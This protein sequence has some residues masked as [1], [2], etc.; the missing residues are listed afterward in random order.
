MSTNMNAPIKVICRYPI[1]SADMYYAE[2]GQRE[3]FASDDPHKGFRIWGELSGGGEVSAIPLCEVFLEYAMLC[4]AWGNDEDAYRQMENFGK[5]LGE[6]A[7][8]YIQEYVLPE[9]L[10]NP[11][12][13]AL[14]CLL[15]SMNAN[16]A[17]EQIGPELRFL[18]YQCPFEET[19][20][21]TGL[22]QTELAH[23]GMNAMCQ[24]LLQAVEPKVVVSSPY[25]EY[26]D[27]IFAM[28]T[29]AVAQA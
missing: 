14:E 5:G 17:V 9:G 22:T 25:H 19:A 1:A 8:F 4:K 7:A 6:A 27:H 13:C 21:R 2:V 18:I 23:V 16:L 11:G 3:V 24:S 29:E 12:A 26:I 20:R 15:E 28:T 10:S